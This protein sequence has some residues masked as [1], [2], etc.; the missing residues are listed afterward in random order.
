M[1]DTK[2]NLKVLA[3]QKEE[4]KNLFEEIAKEIEQ[5]NPALGGFEELGAVLA[6]PD[7]QFAILSPIFLPL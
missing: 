3:P 2:S 5:V 7:D 1:S 4:Q 6:L